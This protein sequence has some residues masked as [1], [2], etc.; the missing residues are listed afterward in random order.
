MVRETCIRRT[1]PRRALWRQI[2]VF[3]AAAVRLGHGA[4]SAR[5]RP[6]RGSSQAPPR[7]QDVAAEE[8]YWAHS[9]RHV[10][11][12]KDRQTLMDS[13]HLGGVEE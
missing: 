7:Q 1:L 12:C 10:L 5:A 8:T 13:D 3:N 11:V 6:A 2:E 4:A 9:V